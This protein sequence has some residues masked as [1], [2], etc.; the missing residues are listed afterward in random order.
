[1]PPTICLRDYIAAMA[2]ASLAGSN[3]PEVIARLAY[4]IADAM[5]GER[6]KQPEKQVDH[7]AAQDVVDRIAKRML[8]E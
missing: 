2:A 5:L 8:S 1:M 6:E 4:K 3:S 7:A